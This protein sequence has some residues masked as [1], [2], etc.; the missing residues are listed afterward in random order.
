MQI[1]PRA[2]Q[3]R[4]TGQNLFL[5]ALGFTFVS[6]CTRVHFRSILTQSF[7]HSPSAGQLGGRGGEE[8]R[9]EAHEN[10][11]PSQNQAKQGTKGQIGAASGRITPK[12]YTHLEI[13]LPIRD[14]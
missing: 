6:R 10:R 1:E 13:T 7:A 2:Q 11:S 3:Q 12:P 9:G 14:P 5:C 8:G 4:A